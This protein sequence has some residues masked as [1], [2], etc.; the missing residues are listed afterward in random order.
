MILDAASA[1]GRPRAVATSQWPVFI[2]LLGGFSILIGDQPLS[3]RNAPKTRALLINLALEPRH[4]VSREALLQALWPNVQNQLASQSL[5]SLIHSLRRQLAASLAGAAPVLYADGRYR[6][7]VEAGIGL[8]VTWF[9]TCASEGERLERAGQSAAAVARYQQAVQAYRG[10][11]CAVGSTQALM[12]CEALRARYLNLL[13]HL[14][15]YH[16]SQQQYADCL[17]CARQ[18]L[19]T[20]P[21]REDAHRLAMRCYMRQGQRAQ[22]LHQ[23]HLCVGV[24]RAE[25][26]AAP[27]PATAALY[28]QIRLNPDQI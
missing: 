24:L 16:F 21:C 23:Y 3:L 4:T 19:L 28:D 12:L 20:D 13:A 6:L 11:L 1:V 2:C 7:N 14:A 15:D 9:E 10:D 25:F 17:E 22:A 26:D 18:I 8:D 5:N 27:E